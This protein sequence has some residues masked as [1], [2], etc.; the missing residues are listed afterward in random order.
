MNINKSKINNEMKEKMHHEALKTL[1][2][3]QQ[4]M[5][6]LQNQKLEERQVNYY[7]S[8]RLMND[9]VNILYKTL[10]KKEYNKYPTELLIIE[11]NLQKIIEIIN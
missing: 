11:N 9:I 7:L 8:F 4:Y 1:C 10:N 3:L 6:N 2:A 5:V